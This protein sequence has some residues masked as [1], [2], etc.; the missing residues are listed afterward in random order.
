MES[1]FDINKLIE[2][3]HTAMI[4]FADIHVIITLSQ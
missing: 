3:G 1:G 2:M 4:E